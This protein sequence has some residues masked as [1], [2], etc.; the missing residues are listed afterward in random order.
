MFNLKN[1]IKFIEIL[2]NGI[3]NH[4]IFI[5]LVFFYIHSTVFGQNFFPEKGFLYSDEVVARIDITIHPDSL[6]KIL[7]GDLTSDH[8]Y[9]ANFKM[10]RGTVI[11]TAENV[12]FRLRGNTSRYSQKKSFKV[13]INSFTPGKKFEGVEKINLNGE[14]NLVL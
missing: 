6:I 14:H 9:P 13:S 4:L 11:K 5:I 8:E 2:R 12:G 1:S 3:K 10:T 7:N